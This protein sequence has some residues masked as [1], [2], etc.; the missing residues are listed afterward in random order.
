MLHEHRADFAGHARPAGQLDWASADSD[1]RKFLILQKAERL[2]KVGYDERQV[3]GTRIGQ[4]WVEW[5]RRDSFYFDGLDGHFRPTRRGGGP[6]NG[7]KSRTAVCVIG[8]GHILAELHKFLQPVMR[9][10]GTRLIAR[11][12]KFQSDKIV[13]EMHGLLD[14]PDLAAKMAGTKN[15]SRRRDSCWRRIQRCPGRLRRGNW[16]NQ[17]HQG[18]RS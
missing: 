15:I 4:R 17:Q 7:K 8:V 1:H 14:V 13:I 3:R 12:A 16:D 10:E 6:R 2:I 11:S 5:A 9:A 18:D